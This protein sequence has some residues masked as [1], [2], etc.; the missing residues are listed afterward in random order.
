MFLS[1]P[2][3][4]A[5]RTESYSLQLL[6]GTQPTCVALIIDL[7]AALR[8]VPEMGS[9]VGN[10]EQNSPFRSITARNPAITAAV[11]SSSA[12]CA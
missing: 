4:A 12:S 6:H 9:A 8:R 7:A 2:A 11:V 10:S 3:P 5:N 1:V